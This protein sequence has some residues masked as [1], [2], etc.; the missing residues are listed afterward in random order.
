MA[1]VLA[2][3]MVPLCFAFLLFGSVTQS[4][5]SFASA[6]A[7]VMLVALGMGVLGGLIQL[8]RGAEHPED[9]R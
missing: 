2:L 5:H 1:A 6:M 9:A 4:E 8:V 3:F 7:M